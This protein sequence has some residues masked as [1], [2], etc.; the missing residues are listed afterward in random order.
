MDHKS[1]YK[2]HLQVIKDNV[3]RILGTC[4]FESL[5]IDAGAAGTFFADDAHLPFKPTPHFAH[6]CPVTD[7]NHLIHY[8]PGTKPK[9]FHVAPQD[10][11]H[12]HRPLTPD[13]WTDDFDVAS[14]P[15]NENVWQDLSSL[16]HVAYIGPNGKKALECGFTPNPTNL[17]AHMD[18]FRAY[19]SD[20]EIECMS[21]A[22]RM[23]AAGHLAAKR[24]FL[25]GATELDIHLGYLHAVG[26][27][28]AS[29]PYRTI[30]CLDERCAILHYHAK[31]RSGKGKTFLIDA[32]ASYAG[33]G[34]DISRTW[35]TG[36][37]HPVYKQLHKGLDRSQKELAA[38][39]RH[40]TPY[41]AVHAKAEMDIAS[42]LI[43]SGILCRISGEQAVEKRLVQP[44]FPH[45][46][47]HLLGVQVHDVGGH[48][49]DPSGAMH[50]RDERYPN[51]RTHR[52][53]EDQMLVTI[54]PGIY[55]I[56]MLLNKF[57][58]GDFATHFNWGLIDELIPFGGIRIE[59]DVLVTSSGGRNLTRE[60]I[61]D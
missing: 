14:S 44:F 40:D 55:F 42:L 17:I 60:H 48:Q 20:Y 36:T 1:T 50:P 2:Q 46:V 28:E 22:N 7:E 38:S 53:L 10:Y 56:P 31:R 35:Y 3:T 9:L 25:E 47:G 5:V 32:G 19:K 26:C 6:W 41:V 30:T 4:G 11:W 37:A 59:D 57:R 43:E 27:E 58:E 18:W 45:G 51:L 52:K 8:S 39:L 61:P 33:Y 34:S 23:A 24:L 12:E 13:Y 49:L 16:R 29:L 21:E 54:E 15:S